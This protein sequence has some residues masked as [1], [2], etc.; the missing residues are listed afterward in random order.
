MVSR[1]LE[2]NQL[3]RLVSLRRS[4]R[5]ATRWRC[6]GTAAPRP[7]TTPSACGLTEEDCSSRIDR[8]TARQ[9]IGVRDLRNYTARVVDAVRSGETVTL[10]LHGEPIADIVP[11]L[12]RGRWI[13]GPELQREL[14][15]ASAD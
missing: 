10:T 12:S 2:R 13:S 5:P 4:L 3:Q 15:T 6:C 14:A 8:L 11:H 1:Y 9:Q 7:S